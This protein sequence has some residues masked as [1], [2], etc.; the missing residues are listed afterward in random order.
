MDG[1]YLVIASFLINDVFHRQHFLI[2][3]HDSVSLQAHLQQCNH[4]HN[5]PCIKGRE[6]WYCGYW[7]YPEGMSSE[8]ERCLSY[9]IYIYIYIYYYYTPSANFHYFEFY[10]S[11]VLLVV[12]FL[13][14]VKV[15]TP[16]CYC[17]RKTMECVV[18]A[19]TSIK[20][21]KHISKI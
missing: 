14:Y 17:E 11:I 10:K 13:F 15:R 5:P 2:F 4:P 8:P 3:C 9:N 20:F 21:N 1:S 12:L 18:S 6:S 16:Y 7:Q 19:F